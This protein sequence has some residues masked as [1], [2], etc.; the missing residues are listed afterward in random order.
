LLSAL[1]SR[2][3]RLLWIG[4][5]ISFLGDQFHLVALPWLVLT[6]T[7]DPLQLG[8]VLACSGI[9]RA[10]FMLL[11][12]AWADRHSPRLIMLAS[13]AIR[14]LVA[15]TLSV[16]ILT[17]TLQLWMVY[18]LAIVFGTVSGFFHP[19]ANAAIPRLLEDEKLES[20]N[21]L[22]QIA[23][24]AAAFLGPAAA[25]VLIAWFGRSVISGE[26]VASLTGI[27]I[28]FGLDALSFALSAV[29]LALMRPL[30]AAADGDEGPRS[31]D[32][33]REGLRWMWGEPEIR[34]MLAIIACANLFVSGPLLVGLP[35]LAN[36]RLEQGAAAF[37]LILSAFAGGN[38]FGMVGAGSLPRPTGRGFV[39]AT[40]TVIG[41]FGIAIGA[42]AF[43]S[44]TWQALPLMFLAGLG[45]GYMSVTFIT[46]LQRVTPE[47]MLGRMMGVYM[48]SMYGLMPLSQV[49][50]GLVV[51]VSLNA[52]FIG[53]GASLVAVAL[54]AATR[55]E[56][57][58]LSTR[59]D[60]KPI[61]T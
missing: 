56:L 24:Q 49:L 5:T 45:N 54:L 25:G 3:Y 9:P 48:L 60:A 23:D 55:P 52:V 46:Q 57:Q 33:I 16:A 53:A 17:N 7:D 19:A 13:D 37:G 36:A 50:A 28:A 32:A 29:C 34:W 41:G 51:S 27:G 58:S 47:A 18:A 31:I 12:G 2:E 4:Q 43:V 8:L 20:G 21:S 38:L 6:L 10:A 15:G 44:E 59:L 30:P 1:S 22:F 14:F 35:V 61:E 11:G 26:E 39:V 40:V 42:L